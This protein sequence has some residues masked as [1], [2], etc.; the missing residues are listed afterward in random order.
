MTDAVVSQDI[1]FALP[2]TSPDESLRLIRE[3]NRLNLQNTKLQAE[4]ENRR[5]QR[6]LRYAKRPYLTYLVPLATATGLLVGIPALV[7]MLV[8]LV[9]T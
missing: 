7:V 9:K 1:P 5:L 6:E 4:A 2:E 3:V 8:M